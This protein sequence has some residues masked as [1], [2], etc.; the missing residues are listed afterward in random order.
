M[1]K[2]LWHAATLVALVSRPTLAYAQCANDAECKG[3][4]I[5]ENG[6]CVV[7]PEPAA[8]APDPA[9]PAPPP[10]PAAPVPA[11]GI[12]KVTFL[13]K[14]SI[15]RADGDNGAHADCKLPCDMAL[16]PGRYTI[17]V[18]D[19]SETMDV[20]DRLTRVHVDEGCT[21]C[22]VAGLIGM[23]AGA[24]LIAGGVAI[25]SDSRNTVTSAV[26]IG[27]GGLVEA[28]GIVLFIVGLSE[29]F[30]GIEVEQAV[31]APPPFP[32]ER[33]SGGVGLTF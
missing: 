1:N 18:D 31:M 22:F 29:G 26:L 3:D 11:P 24:P 8:P 20:S 6:T 27:S 16:E 15:V 13:G 19:M 14:D 5:C 17:R 23:I 10:A 28:T 25:A 30:G 12:P 9:A 7:P 2:A 32:G 21:F 33:R 4:R